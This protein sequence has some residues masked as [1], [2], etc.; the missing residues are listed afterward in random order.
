MKTTFAESLPVYCAALAVWMGISGQPV[1]AQPYAGNVRQAVGNRVF[2]GQYPQRFLGCT[3]GKH[4]ISQPAEPYVLK[5]DH[6]HRDGQNPPQPYNS[7]FALEAVT[8]RVL[9]TNA[10]GLLLVADRLLDCRPYHQP[11]SLTTWSGSTVRAWLE[12]GFFNGSTATPVQADYF[13]ADEKKAIVLS[14]MANPT[15]GF[16]K[17]PDGITTQD[18]VFLPATEDSM[19]FSGAADRQAFNTDYAA[20]YE[21]TAEPWTVADSWLLRTHSTG[22]FAGYVSYVRTNGMVNSFDGLANG[23]P[24]CIRPALHLSKDAVVLLS[25]GSKPAWSPGAPLTAVSASASDTLKL[26]LVG[27]GLTL[28]SSDDGSYKNTAAGSTLSLN[29]SGLSTGTGRYI[30]CVLEQQGGNTLYYSKIAEASASSGSVNIPVPSGLAPGAYVLKLFCEAPSAAKQTPDLASRPVV[31]YLGTGPATA[32]QL[33]AAVLPD[34]WAGVAYGGY[35]LTVSGTPKPVLSVSSGSLPPGLILDADGRIHGTPVS[36]GTFSFD[37][38]AVNGGG[39]DT[40]S[41]T[42]VIRSPAAPSITAPSAGALPEG[43][44]GVPIAPVS[45]TVTGTPKPTLSLLSGKLPEGL[46]LDAAAGVIRGTPVKAEHAG[47]T[48]QASN[49]LGIDSKT[50]SMTVRSTGPAVAPKITTLADTLPIAG[51]NMPYYFKIEATGTPKPTFDISAPLPAGLSFNFTTGEISGTPLLPDAGTYTTFSVTAKNGSL[52]DDVR[53][54]VLPVAY[55]LPPPVLT[56]TP[57]I[58]TAGTDPFGMTATFGV[59]VSGLTA[60]DIVVNGGSVSG[61][62]M[63][64]PT[65]TPARATAW[66]FR[67]TPDPAAPDGTVIKIHV[68]KGAAQ[69]EH[70]A[71]TY[72]ESDTTHITYHVDVPVIVFGVADGTVFLSDMHGF[73]FDLLPYGTGAE[74]SR[75]FVD[76]AAATAANM[77]GLLEISRNGAPYTGWTLDLRGTRASVN[78]YFGKGDYTVLVKGDRLTNNVGKHAVQRRLHFSV[79]VS[80]NWYEGCRQ[81]FTLTYPASASDRRIS[82]ACVGLSDYVTAPDGNRL[83]AQM[84]LPA[85]QTSMTFSFGT[86]AVPAGLEGDSAGIVI[87]P[88]GLPGATYWF[89]LYNRPK[90]EDVVYIPVTTLY[91]GYFKLLKGGSPHLQRSLDGGLHWSNARSQASALELADAGNRVLFREPDGCETTVIPLATG[92]DMTLQRRVT[93]PS[94]A[95]FETSPIAGIYNVHSGS[96]FFFKVKL[97]GPY[98]GM[99][100]VITTDRSVPDSIGV[101]VERSGEDSYDV[102][103][104]VVRESIHITLR[105]TDITGNAG[106]EATRVWTAGNQLYIASVRDD[107]ANVYTSSGMLLKSIPVTAGKTVRTDLPPGI[108]VVRLT[109]GGVFKVNGIF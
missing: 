6:R 97:T 54:Y 76:G 105:A 26:T 108:H 94:T 77:T 80:K 65:G 72:R 67:V 42:V 22:P 21:N 68:R 16:G 43:V 25:D 90:A 9:A 60:D 81:S 104:R 92:I 24:A 98:A 37:V 20:S 29:Y 103:I 56:L 2:F 5:R 23:M 33:G 75:F 15:V 96:D 99:K 66:T 102:R 83:P 106:I 39:S 35:T 18:H 8:W 107:E 95:H 101:I 73:F 109:R 53:T 31:V 48:I 36:T 70:G 7:Y 14:S 45:F 11:A 10:Q 28:S 4:H 82:L 69:D 79:Q 57:P 27:S 41:Y 1:A 84:I 13:S 19:Y 87:T 61:V 3:Q 30:S 78:G 47:F 17:D 51:V 74:A 100:P 86:R 64:N 52:P 88:D 58:A 34:G 89:R 49:A 55:T 59:P 32:P 71:A 46:L 62:S 38:K 44:V 50:Y 91:S 63:S 93:L 40:K 12:S 85:G